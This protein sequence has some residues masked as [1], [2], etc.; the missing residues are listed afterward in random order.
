MKNQSR[1]AQF[2]TVNSAQAIV[3]L[4]SQWGAL[5]RIE[6]MQKELNE[7]HLTE[8][9]PAC[10]TDVFEIKTTI[11]EE[12]LPVTIVVGLCLYSYKLREHLTE[13]VFAICTPLES[14][15]RTRKVINGYMRA[16]RETMHLPPPIASDPGQ[17]QN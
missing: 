5:D 6:S 7:G 14:V 1:K 4:L 16:M 15:K 11:E 8:S 3:L 2:V 12:D 9:R 13:M 17:R 10:I